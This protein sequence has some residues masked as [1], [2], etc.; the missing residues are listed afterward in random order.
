M[1]C[2]GNLCTKVFLTQKRA[3][4]EKRF[5]GL[6]CIT[7]LGLITQSKINE[8]KEFFL[9]FFLNYYRVCDAFLGT[10][11]L[12]SGLKSVLPVEMVMFSSKEQC[13]GFTLL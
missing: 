7:L 12:F 13:A 11:M 4:Q 2:V 5:E 8:N 1:K 6:N 9:R 3:C 10:S